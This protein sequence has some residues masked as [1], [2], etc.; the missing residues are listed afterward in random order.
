MSKSTMVRISTENAAWIGARVAE[1]GATFQACVNDLIDRDRLLGSAWHVRPI[2]ESPGLSDTFS[3]L[4]AGATAALVFTDPAGAS[5]LLAGKIGALRPMTVDITPPGGDAL[6]LP[7]A[8]IYAWEE[9]AFGNT[10]EVMA[11]A[12]RWRGY[13]VQLHPLAGVLHREL[14]GS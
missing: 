4:E 6:T 14:R 8:K 5:W 9:L 13:G 1:T 7:R 12:F 2:V 10:R 3:R 11:L